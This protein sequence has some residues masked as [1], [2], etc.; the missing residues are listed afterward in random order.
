MQEIIS[1][2]QAFSYDVVVDENCRC[3]SPGPSSI[4]SPDKTQSVQGDEMPPPSWWDE[5]C[6]FRKQDAIPIHSVVTLHRNLS[7]SL[8]FFFHPFV[9]GER[10]CLFSLC[11]FVSLTHIYHATQKSQYKFL[12]SEIPTR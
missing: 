10:F 4:T 11:I 2:C 12:I 6:G 8:F 1:V 7:F 9:E 3:V 5:G